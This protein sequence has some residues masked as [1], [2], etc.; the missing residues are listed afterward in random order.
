[1]ALDQKVLNEE[2]PNKITKYVEDIRKTQEFLTV[3]HEKKVEAAMFRTRMQYYTQGEKNS[4]YFFNLERKRG[5]SKAISS[6]KIDNRIIKNPKRILQEEAL[7]YK[8]LYSDNSNRKWPYVNESNNK[9]SEQEKEDLDAEFTDQ[10]ISQSLAGMPNSKTPGSDGISADFYKMFWLHLKSIYCETICYL[11]NCGKLHDSARQGI[12]TLLP[13]KDRDPQYLKNWRP[14]TLLNVDYKIVARMMAL[15]AKPKLQKLIDHD[16]T[17]F[18]QGC[19]IA[20]NLRTVLD[21]MQI[22]RDRKLQMIIIT[23]DWEKCV[24]KISHQAIDRAFE[25]FNFGPK[26][27]ANIQT[28]FRDS[29]SCVLNKWLFF[30]K[31]SNSVRL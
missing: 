2:D 23:M 15:R 20:H 30:G 24:D 17:G 27:R 4:R 12:I 3:E 8:K 11:L 18:L 16:Q 9:L 21:I 22:A 28:L 7:F 13:K 31:I 10:E 1:M 14:L 29:V 6:L 5:H 25:Y 26:F 19:N